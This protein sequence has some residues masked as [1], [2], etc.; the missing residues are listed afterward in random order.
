LLRDETPA[1]RAVRVTGTLDTM[2][3]SSRMILLILP[4]GEKIQA[5]LE[6]PDFELLPTLFR[7]RVTIS[8]MAR[9]RPS[10]RLLV[11]DAEYLGPAT[12]NDTIWERMPTARPGAAAPVFTPMPQDRASGVA[13][14]FGIWSGEESEQDLLRALEE[15]E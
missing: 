15:I 13:A 12:P 1:P 3:A 14:F 5:R 9:F 4:D 2:S 6:E 11:M 8:G 7:Q 10:G